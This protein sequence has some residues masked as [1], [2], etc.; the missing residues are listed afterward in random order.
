MFKRFRR[1]VSDLEGG[2][3]QVGDGDVLQVVLQR[4][5]ERRHGELQGVSV[6][7]DHRVEQE[8]GRLRHADC[9]HTQSQNNE[10]LGSRA[11]GSVHGLTFLLGQ[12][13]EQTRQNL[14]NL[15]H[16]YSRRGEEAVA[17][18]RADVADAEDERGVLDHQHGQADVLQFPVCC[19]E[20]NQNQNQNHM[21]EKHEVH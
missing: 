10:P 13:D 3:G 9:R 5:D 11:I 2:S 15:S 14:Q 1:A 20:Q 16:H 19:K 7:K 17:R 6:L 18:Q 4:V 21:E 8:V 12:D